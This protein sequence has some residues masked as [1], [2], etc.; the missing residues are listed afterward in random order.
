MTN[1]N[2]RNKLI[3]VLDREEYIQK[4][5]K[6]KEYLQ[7]NYADIEVVYTTYENK[8]I[9]RVRSW[10]FIGKALQHLLYWGLSYQFAGKIYKKAENCDVLCINPIVAIFLGNKNKKKKYNLTMCGFLFEEKKNKLYYNMRKKFTLKAM[11]G[12][13]RIVVYGS[14]EV[15]YYSELFGVKNKFYFVPF[16]MDYFENRQYYGKLPEEYLFSGGGSNRDYKT[17]L[18]AYEI[19]KDNQKLPLCIATNPLLLPDKL[20]KHV[21][22]IS[23]VVV[24]NFGM[25]LGKAK[26]LILSLKNIELSAGHMVMLQALAENVPVIVNRISAVEDYV[27]EK[28]VLFFESGNSQDLAEKID[29]FLSGKWKPEHTRAFYERNYTFSAML[30]RIVELE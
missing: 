29:S 10:K 1:E 21:K 12:M 9:R 19:M 3:L 15:N 14:R 8:L 27:T 5:K 16:G 24:E 20:P 2:K 26:C 7:E 18:D 11:E 30:K 25:V 4:E 17:L 22:L 28:E 13:N 6:I 23:D